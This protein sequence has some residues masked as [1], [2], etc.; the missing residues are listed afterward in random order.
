MY[1]IYL[2]LLYLLSFNIRTKSIIKYNNDNYINIL[3]CKL[4]YAPLSSGGVGLHL[5]Q[6]K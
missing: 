1:I 2:T 6:Q 5:P 4:W 3:T